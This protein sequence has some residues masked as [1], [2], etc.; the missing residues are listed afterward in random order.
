MIFFKW[1]QISFIIRTNFFFLNV[2]TD[3][4]QCRG[5]GVLRLST[6][7]FFP[8]ILFLEILMW[9]THGSWL[10]QKLGCLTLYKLSSGWLFVLC[11]KNIFIMKANILFLKK[12]IKAIWKCYLKKRKHLSA[13]SSPDHSYFC[14]CIIR[15]SSSALQIPPSI[16]CWRILEYCCNKSPFLQMTPRLLPLE[17]E[18]LMTFTPLK[19]NH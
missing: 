18:T 8:T 13:S 12:V 2:Y 15:F 4:H 16:F 6:K 5:W 19:Q 1:A 17:L 3:D 9:K 10:G 11:L 7:H 14:T